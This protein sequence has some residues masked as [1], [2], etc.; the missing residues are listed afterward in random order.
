MNEWLEKQETKVLIGLHTYLTNVIIDRA[1]TT[2]EEAFKDA[3]EN[4]IKIRIISLIN[5]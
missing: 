2:Q 1:L 4:T 3:I 5:E